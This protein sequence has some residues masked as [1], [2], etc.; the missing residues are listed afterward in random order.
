ML[1]KGWGGVGVVTRC[2]CDAGLGGDVPIP[3]F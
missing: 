1:G 2:G 3:I